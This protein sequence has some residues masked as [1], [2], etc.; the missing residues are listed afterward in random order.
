MWRAPASF[1][2]RGSELTFF[3]PL[4]PSLPC[5]RNSRV[6]WVTQQS[7]AE[8]LHV[9]SCLVIPSSVR[10]LRRRLRPGLP[11]APEKKTGR[12][13]AYCWCIM[14]IIM[15]MVKNFA[16]VLHV[17]MQVNF[18]KVNVSYSVAFP[19]CWLVKRAAD[20]W[21][22][23]TKSTAFWSVLTW[24]CGNTCF[25]KEKNPIRSLLLA[26]NKIDSS[27]WNE[28]K[29]DKYMCDVSWFCPTTR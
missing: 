18:W 29:R 14:V 16:G 7:L 15:M 9:D 26:K 27:S 1:Y 25:P 22:H 3:F 20:T 2:C 11:P 6:Q 28:K 19:R 12:D 5:S 24:T 8:R 21:T 23:L 4:Q 10:A 13:A 17:Y